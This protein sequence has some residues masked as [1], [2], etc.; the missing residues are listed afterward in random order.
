[1]SIG[2]A[3]E[4]FPPLGHVC[5]TLDAFPDLT[6]LHQAHPDRYPHLLESVAHGTAQAR[7]DILFAFPEGMIMLDADHRLYRNGELLG[8]GKFLEAF[9]REWRRDVLPP[10]TDKDLTRQG[11]PLPFTGGWFVFLGYELASEIEPVLTNI[12]RNGTLPIASATRIPAAVVRD[13]ATRAA[14]L[15]CEADKQHALL[16]LMQDDIESRREGDDSPFGMA[17]ILEERPAQFLDGVRRVQDYIRAGDV[18]QVNLSR[19]WQAELGRPTDPIHLYRRL[20]AANPAPFSGL[21][22]FGGDRAII[23]SSPER[24]VHVNRRTIRT[25]PIAGTYPR[26]S[27]PK[28]DRAWSRELLGHPKERAEHVMLIDL[29]R[30]DL[31]RVCRPGMVKVSELM[32][33]ESYRHVHHIVSEI[34][35]ELRQGVT[36]AQIFRALFPGGTI[37][38][39][40]KVRCMEIIAELEQT[41]RGPY[42]GSM[43]YVNRDGSLDLNILIRTLVQ[44]GRDIHLRAGAGIVA[45]SIPERE[46]QETR[47]KAK[48]LLAAMEAM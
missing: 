15:V 14:H 47:A 36:P 16:P 27:D 29:E 46:L 1:V 48:G 32:V 30:N 9:D 20:R 10:G 26:S 38:G 13:H 3:Q 17:A 4:K 5:L 42:T 12:P 44:N 18:F 23:S 6:A 40:P 33:L 2:L 11:V 34:R 41:T 31:G 21:M 19:L 43:G 24:L 25:R 39:C 45:D 22:T 37:T 7:Y 28:Q 35:G 8:Q